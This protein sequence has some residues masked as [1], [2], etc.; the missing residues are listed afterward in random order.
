MLTGK[1]VK[2]IAGFYYVHDGGRVWACRAAGIFRKLGVKPLVGDNAEFEITD[3]ADGEGSVTRILPRKNRLIRPEVANIDQALIVFAISSPDPNFGVLD[4]LLVNMELNAVPC[5]I[6]FNKTDLSSA[7]ISEEELRSAYRGSECELLFTSVREG[8]GIE[9][10]LE[11]L[12]GKTTVLAGPSGVGKS[13][14]MNILLPAANAETGEVSRKIKRGRQTT[15][16][17]EI[18]CVE[19]DTYVL[20]TPG[21]TSLEVTGIKEEE[22]RH[23]FPEF[24]SFVKDC[25]FPDCVHVGERE[26]GVKDAVARG[27]ISR[28]RYESYKSIYAEL[29]AARKY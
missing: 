14:L 8:R 10:V 17:S 24:E 5:V 16:H 9:A 11:R 2:G 18:F 1:I 4:R 20:D 26:C 3:E 28:S 6:C 19:R 23:C 29:K 27:D 13:S 7:R 25:R 22:L 21:F 12:R 15:R